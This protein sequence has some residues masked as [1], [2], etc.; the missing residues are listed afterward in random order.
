M[1]AVELSNDDSPP[2]KKSGT[3]K[4]PDS[5][6][7]TTWQSAFSALEKS[8]ESFKVAGIAVGIFH[9]VVLVVILGGPERGIGL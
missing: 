3:R 6:G 2:K 5:G 1:T 4:A 8:A 7:R 9:Q